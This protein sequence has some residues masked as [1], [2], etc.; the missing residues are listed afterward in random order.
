MI[1]ASILVPSGLLLYGFS[2]SHHLHPLLPNTGI[3]VYSL[4]III[5]YQCIQTYMIDCY[6]TYAASAIG[7]LTILRALAGCAFPMFAPALFR[8]FG[9]Q[10]GSSLL[11]AT[12]TIIGGAAPW[13]IMRWGPRLRDRSEYARGEVRIQL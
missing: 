7:S 1:P 6:P 3:A 9:Y 8:Q 11:A 2:A 13:M 12:A 4:G 5:G 10:G